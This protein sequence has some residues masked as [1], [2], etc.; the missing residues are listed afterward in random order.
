MSLTFSTIDSICIFLFYNFTDIYFPAAA[1]G[2]VWASDS[3]FLLVCIV[4]AVMSLSVVLNPLCFL[5]LHVFWIADI[6]LLPGEFIVR[7]DLYLER[8]GLKIWWVGFSFCSQLLVIALDN[9]F[10]CDKFHYSLLISSSNVLWATPTH[11][12]LLSSFLWQISKT[13]RAEH[14]SGVFTHKKTN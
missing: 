11:F 8:K 10:L 5:S 14:W 6:F 3:L 4:Q 2:C 1:A 9:N 12:S 7:V 13:H